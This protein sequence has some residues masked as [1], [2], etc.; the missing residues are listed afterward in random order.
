LPGHPN[1]SSV[2]GVQKSGA[3]CICGWLLGPRSGKPYH[4]CQF[5]GYVSNS[6][7]MEKYRCD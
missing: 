5:M 7:T 6:F 2:Y 4:C 3:D 1:L